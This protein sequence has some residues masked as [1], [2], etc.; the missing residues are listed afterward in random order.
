MDVRGAAL[1]G[2]G[3]DDVDQT[4]H[5]R[6]VRLVGQGVDVELFRLFVQYLEGA[7]W[8]NP[9]EGIRGV[10]QPG[11]ERG[12]AQ[13]R[14]DHCPGSCD[15]QESA[16]IHTCERTFFHRV[17]QFCLLSLLYG[18]VR[19]IYFTSPLLAVARTL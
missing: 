16:T 6:L 12:R 2:V 11:R 17:H 9:G 14:G 4:H 10:R 19:R 15:L 8:R 18:G 13:R 1:D 7:A 5:R 3:E